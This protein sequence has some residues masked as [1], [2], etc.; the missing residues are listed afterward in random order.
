MK[1]IFSNWDW[2]DTW[3]SIFAIFTVLFTFLLFKF[4]TADHIVRYYYLTGGFTNTLIIRADIDYGEDQSIILDRSITYEQAVDM[5]E[6][7]NG[8]LR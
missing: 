2:E 5:V 7:L 8:T 4:F 3:L 1:N 6:R